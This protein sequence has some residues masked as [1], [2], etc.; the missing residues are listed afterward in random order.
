MPDTKRL[1]A[2]I[3]EAI[4]ALKPLRRKG[5]PEGS[6]LAEA[7]RERFAAGRPFEI[8]MGGRAYPVKCD[9]IRVS[10][11]TVDLGIVGADGVIPLTRVTSCEHGRDE[12]GDAIMGFG[13]YEDDD[14]IT[15]IALP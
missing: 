8:L 6:L 1:V 3:D 11:T 5:I 14:S 15:P 10:K 13:V 2:K 4:K 12:D 7:L 9:N